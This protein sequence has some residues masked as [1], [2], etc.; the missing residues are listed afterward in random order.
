MSY[1]K[2]EVPTLSLKEAK[3]R[4]EGTLYKIDERNGEQYVNIIGL[5]KLVREVY[6]EGYR[7]GHAEAVG[8]DVPAL[9]ADIENLKANLE[10]SQATVEWKDSVI[11]QQENELRTANAARDT[12]REVVVMLSRKGD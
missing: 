1:D 7:A 4:V 3:D 2:Y 6:K 8:A 12:Y 10:T 5:I 11:R 9:K